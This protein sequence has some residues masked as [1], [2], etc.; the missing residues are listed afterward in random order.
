MANFRNQQNT[1][2]QQSVVHESITKA[3]FLLASFKKEQASK[4]F[5]DGEFIKHCLVETAGLVCPDTKNK[6][7]QISLSRRTV[8]RRIEQID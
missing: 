7:E 3:S 1:L 8:T 4:S 2:F 6:Y 5:S